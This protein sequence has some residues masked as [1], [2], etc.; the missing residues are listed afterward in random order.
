MAT[1]T[2]KDLV[3][4]VAEKT[5]TSQSIVKTIVQAFLDEIVSELARNNRLEFRDFGVFEVR[6]AAPRTAQNP[7]TLEKIQVPAKRA[8]KFKMGRIMREKVNAKAA[9]KR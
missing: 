8:V 9:K 2:K 1:I 6:E 4:K 5:K 3:D 7:K